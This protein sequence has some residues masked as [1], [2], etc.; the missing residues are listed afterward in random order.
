MYV[1]ESAGFLSSTFLA[2][3]SDLFDVDPAMIG[4]PTN[5]SLLET[6]GDAFSIFGERRLISDD[7]FRIFGDAL[8]TFGDVFVTLS[9]PVSCFTFNLFAYS[10]PL[11][12]TN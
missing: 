6:I 5:F 8:E 9:L 2:S 12:F 11:S 10:F 1:F 4:F 3:R 7:L